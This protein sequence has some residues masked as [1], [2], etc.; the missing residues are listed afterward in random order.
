MQVEVL[1]RANL[2]GDEGLLIRK[3]KISSKGKGLFSR[4]R[5]RENREYV[6]DRGLV[7]YGDLIIVCKG[8][9]FSIMERLMEEEDS[10]KGGINLST[11]NLKPQLDKSNFKRSV[12]KVKSPVRL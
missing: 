9:P 5:E 7:A 4:E 2:V 11:V 1:A 8:I 3:R 12:L 10:D 6:Q